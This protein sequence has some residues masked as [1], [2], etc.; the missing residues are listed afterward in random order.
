MYELISFPVV[1]VVF[2]V[3]GFLISFWNQVSGKK[4]LEKQ[5]ADLHNTVV[6]ES[7]AVAA[8]NAKYAFVL[9]KAGYDSVTIDAEQVDQLQSFDWTKINE[10]V[11]NMK[12]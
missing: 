3:V 5:I 6:S 8:L 2:L 7:Q 11:S 12:K 10:Y 1:L 4:V 9:V